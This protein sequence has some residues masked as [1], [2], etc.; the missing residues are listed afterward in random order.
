MEWCGVLMKIGYRSRSRG[1]MLG[2][3]VEPKA[4]G[5]SAYRALIHRSELENDPEL[6]ELI[7]PNNQTSV[8][9]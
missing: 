2:E 9:W 1:E 4:S 7:D 5:N 6:A 3:Y 8:V